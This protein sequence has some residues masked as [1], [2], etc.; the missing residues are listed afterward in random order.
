MATSQIREILFSQ[1]ADTLRKAP[2]TQKFGTFFL[3]GPNAAVYSLTVKF[4]DKWEVD[5]CS[6]YLS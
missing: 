5:T 6:K 4:T 1:I 3:C 2:Q